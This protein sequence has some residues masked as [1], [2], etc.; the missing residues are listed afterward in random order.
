MIWLISRLT[1]VV[2]R[3]LFHRHTRWGDTTVTV[4]WWIV[5]QFYWR[6]ILSWRII[7]NWRWYGN[8]LWDHRRWRLR[9]KQRSCGFGCTSLPIVNRPTLLGRPANFKG[10]PLGCWCGISRDNEGAQVAGSEAKVATWALLTTR[11]IVEFSL[12]FAILWSKEIHAVTRTS[13]YRWMKETTQLQRRY[14]L[15]KPTLTKLITK[16]QTR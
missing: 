13:R 9:N 6:V 4:Q 15:S 11:G 8:L 3:R 16:W 10:F 1:H 14:V 7:R 12:I 2:W 5:P